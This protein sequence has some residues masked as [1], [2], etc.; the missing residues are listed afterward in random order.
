MQK[1]LKRS[2]RERKKKKERK[3]KEIEKKEKKNK[4]YL[5]TSCKKYKRTF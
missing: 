5:L 4:T 2:M 1:F 3:G